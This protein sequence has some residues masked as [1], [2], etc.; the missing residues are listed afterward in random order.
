MMQSGF[1]VKAQRK[2]NKGVQ[3]WRDVDIT[4]L[5][6]EEFVNWW[7][8]IQDDR[9]KFAIANRLRKMTVGLSD[10]GDSFSP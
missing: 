5:S 9:D 4:E 8:S 7:V 1:L 6:D 3:E 10:F 2:N